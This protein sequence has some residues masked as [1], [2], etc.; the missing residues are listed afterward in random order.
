MNAYLARIVIVSSRGVLVN[1]DEASKDKRISSWFN[2]VFFISV[3]NTNVSEIVKRLIENGF[4]FSSSHL[5]S[6]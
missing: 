4:N 2:L 3:A 1:K 5:A 6:A